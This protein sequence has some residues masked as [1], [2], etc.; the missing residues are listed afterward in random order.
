MPNQKITS[1][2][3]VPE[4]MKRI[5]VHVSNGYVGCR[6][7]TF[8]DVEE[9][10]TDRDIDDSAREALFEMIEWGWEPVTRWN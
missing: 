7:E 4:G 9:D 3:P 8:I 10:L 2:D 1:S 6:R 5:R